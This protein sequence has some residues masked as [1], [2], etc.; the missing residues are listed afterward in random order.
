MIRRCAVVYTLSKP[1]EA[2]DGHNMPMGSKD[3]LTAGK[4]AASRTAKNLRYASEWGHTFRRRCRSRAGLI[5]QRQYS[6]TL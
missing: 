5:E 1:Q 3:P 2:S 6:N 4:T